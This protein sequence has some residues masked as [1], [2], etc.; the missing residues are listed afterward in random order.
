MI[1]TQKSVPSTWVLLVTKL[2]VR[3]D[4]V[5]LNISSG[6]LWVQDTPSMSALTFI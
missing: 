2:V 1:L 5:Y 6:S 3:G 4:L